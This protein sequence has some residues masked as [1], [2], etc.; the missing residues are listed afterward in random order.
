MSE[1][2][3][4]GKLPCRGDFVQR[5]APQGFVDAWD[6][7]LQE[8]LHVSRQQLGERWLDLYL[9]SPVWR[10][11][12]AEGICGESAYAGVML[13]SVDRVGR[14]FPL[15]L[16]APLEP[17]GCILEAACGAGRAW[18]DAA[19]ELALRALDAS[20]LDVQ[21]F[22]AEVDALPG[23]AAC[24]AIGESNRLM[25]RLAQ[26]AFARRASPWHVSMLGETPQRAVNAFASMELQKAFRPCALW[27][28]QGSEAVQPGWLVMSGLPTPSG[29]SAML[30][31]QWL[32]AGWNSVE[33][34]AQAPA[35]I[36]TV[37]EASAAEVPEPVDLQIVV[38]QAPSRDGSVATRYIRRPEA[39]LWG[40]VMAAGG[41][42]SGARA[43][44]LADVAYDLPPQAT[45]T[46]GIESARRA[47]IRVLAPATAVILFLT[48]RTECALVWSGSM[49]AVR[50]R[51][52]NV[53][54][55]TKGVS[56]MEADCAVEATLAPQLARGS[57]AA[58]D[59]GLLALL[60]APATPEPALSVRYE[61]LEA[62]DLWVLG[63]DGSMADALLG[64]LASSWP[65]AGKSAQGALDALLAQQAPARDAAGSA[66]ALMLIAAQPAARTTT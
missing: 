43:D 20:D 41:A 1:T 19:E 48:G 55:L 53:V 11:V 32:A 6:A 26:A 31:G 27:W 61:A 38:S 54:E 7:W 28:T 62:N 44:L 34:A 58:D 52:G 10:F 60:T 2:G 50:L 16:V 3:F 22:D 14:Y 51:G 21:A 64:R 45:L 5:R 65:G 40:V 46:A 33:V 23:L 63:G 59:G 25:E 17:G 24:E 35:Q 47:L 12:L 30:S 29:Y 13:P 49:Q 37:C 57:S 15:T 56:P 9:T 18:F 8:C 4:Y 42:D 66:P 39:G 36:A